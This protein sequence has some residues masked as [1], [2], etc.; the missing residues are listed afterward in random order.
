MLAEPVINCSA[1]SGKIPD[2][3]IW[4]T[5]ASVKNEP[6]VAGLTTAGT[7]AIQLEAHFSNMPQ[8]GKLKALICMATPR[9]GTMI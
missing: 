5:T 7:P 1:P 3:I 4:R 6:F 2:S 8:T 9:L